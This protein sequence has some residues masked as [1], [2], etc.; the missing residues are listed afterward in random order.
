LSVSVVGC[1][2]GKYDQKYK[3]DIRFHEIIKF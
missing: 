2:Y 3:N 1:S